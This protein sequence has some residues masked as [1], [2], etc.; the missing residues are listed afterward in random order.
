MEWMLLAS[1]RDYYFDGHMERPIDI[2]DIAHHLAMINRF[3]GATLRPYSD[4]EHSL[5][6]SEIAQREGAAPILQWLA[7]MHD[8]HE[9]VTGDMSSPIKRV[10]NKISDCAGG[11]RA[12]RIF[13]SQHEQEMHR[14]FRVVGYFKSYARD[15]HRIDGVA[16]ATERRDLTKFNP[17]TNAPWPV[18]RD[19]ERDA[20]LPVDWVSL[21]SVEREAMTWR[22]WKAAF[23]A[24]H[25]ELAAQLPIKVEQAH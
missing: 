9:F 8:A 21:N 6:C 19:L 17:A 20:V 23:L 15:I 14:H 11:V 7:L 10:I 22:Q 4:A 3:G 25:N 5:L 2:E 18:L 12:W 1:G 16:L 24:R 13:E